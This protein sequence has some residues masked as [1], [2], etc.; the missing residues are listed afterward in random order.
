[1]FAG[2]DPTGAIEYKLSV[3]GPDYRL[4]PHFRLIEFASRDGADVVKV[5]PAL[6]SGLEALRTAIDAPLTVN[7]GYRT[8]SHNA[9]IGGV[10]NSRHCLGM[11][12][13]IVGRGVSVRKVRKAAKR[14]GFGGV[15]KYKTFTHVDVWGYDRRW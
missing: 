1:M 15:G 3:H 6:V 2:H 7:S 9:N 14:L 5:H 10:R 11:A 12:A 8:T 4:S 13:D